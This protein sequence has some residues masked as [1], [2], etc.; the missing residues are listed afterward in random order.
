M[1]DAAPGAISAWHE[2]G[3]IIPSSHRDN[4]RP[5][6]DHRHQ[7]RLSVHPSG[8]PD[9]SLELEFTAH[10][11]RSHPEVFWFKS[12][13]NKKAQKESEPLS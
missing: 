11:G 4:S 1:M 5:W 10:R 8:T 2:I 9:A 12:C 6:A 3:T 13:S 7:K